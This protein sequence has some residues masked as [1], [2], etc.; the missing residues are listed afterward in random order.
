MDNNSAIMEAFVQESQEHLGA[1]ESTLLLMEEKGKDSD[2]ETINEAFRA[3]HSI[4]GSAGFFGLQKVTALSHTMENLMAK[5]RGNS[6]EPTTPV[7]DALLKG[8]DKLKIMIGDIS[9]SE[10]VDASRE[11]E[12][13][14]GI[15][16]GNGFPPAGT[17]TSKRPQKGR[18]RS[19]KSTPKNKKKN[20][21][22]GPHLVWTHPEEEWEISRYKGVIDEA[23]ANGRS[24]YTFSFHIPAKS[25]EKGSVVKGFKTH[26]S[27]LGSIVA[28]NPDIG[29]DA[30]IEDIC[31]GKKGVSISILFST[32]LEKDLLSDALQIPRELISKIELERM[33]GL[34]IVSRQP[35][36]RHPAEI[37]LSIERLHPEEKGLVEMETDVCIPDKPQ[38]I[39]QDLLAL[40]KVG[41]GTVRIKVNLLDNILR[42]AGELVLT[43]NQLMRQYGDKRTNTTLLT[44]SQQVTELQEGVMKT[45]LQPVGDVFSKFRRIV[46]DMAQQV[47]KEVNLTVQGEDVELDRSIIEA[48]SDP[49][50]HLIRNSIDHA[51]E[52]PDERERLGKPR[53]GAIH[54]RA[55]QEGGHVIIEVED[56][57]RGISPA[58]VKEKA[59]EKGLITEEMAERM[60]DKE[61]INLIFRPGFSTADE[62]SLIS[63]RGVGMDVVKSSF[64]RLGGT[65]DLHTEEGKGTLVRMRVPL[66][67]A[68]VPSLVVTVE[69]L[70]FVI[71][72]VDVVEIVRLKKGDKEHRIESIEGQSV[73]RLRGRLLPV[74]HLRDVLEIK[75]SSIQDSKKLIVLRHGVNP[76]GLLVDDVLGFEEVMV[77]PLPA[78]VKSCKTFVGATIMG[79]GNVAMILSITGIVDRCRFNFEGLKKKALEYE[80]ERSKKGEERE[81]ILIFKNS[82]EEYFAMPLSEVRRIEKVEAGRIEQVGEREFVQIKGKVLPLIRL[83]EYLDVRQGERK[84]VVFIIIPRKDRY[85]IGIIA[86]EIIDAVRTG[87]TIDTDSIQAPGLLGS[88]IINNRMTLMLDT[89]TLLGMVASSSH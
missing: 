87:I 17:T 74:V 6:I 39:D 83:E 49:L 8:L 78:P 18:P 25:E 41:G 68:I 70:R 22:E 62:V 63:G 15:I 65:V 44:Y 42:L 71:P 3:I 30:R 88:C 43:R 36:I 7:I 2:M 80:M 27:S 82:P 55:F 51:I 47:R 67:L 69:G 29:D 13:I 64:E 61:L 89:S 84:D 58:R 57:G 45:R 32:V 9:A 5:V 46:R 50:T 81:N 11:V 19:S 26:L 37:P 16:D 33:M 21:E 10:G 4:K 86:T 79:D 73:F 72:Q 31:R 60:S 20:K 66:T 52:R 76:F 23:I 35:S 1:A 53:A 34:P 77:K 38:S 28:S 56:D 85:Q 14:K 75:Q 54:L 48:L 40:R 12:V 24:L 59:I